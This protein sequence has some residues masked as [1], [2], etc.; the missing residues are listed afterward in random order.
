MT[1]TYDDANTWRRELIELL[2]ERDR[3][4]KENAALKLQIQQLQNAGAQLT[5]ELALSWLPALAACDGWDRLALGQ[6]R[7]DAAAGRVDGLGLRALVMDLRA[8]PAS[9]TD[10]I[11]W[12]ANERRRVE[13]GGGIPARPAPD[14]VQPIQ[15]TSWLL[16]QRQP[17]LGDSFTALTKGLRGRLP[18]V[19]ETGFLLWGDRAVAMLSTDPAQVVEALLAEVRRVS[20]ATRAESRRFFFDLFGGAAAKQQAR[21]VLGVGPEASQGEIKQAY[22]QLARQHHPDAGG[23][24]EQFHRIQQAY[25]LLAQPAVAGAG[26]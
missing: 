8:V 19:I 21:Q 14:R 3:L 12:D 4:A 23:D 10:R 7:W 5:P 20:E 17:G 26:R 11:I 16:N 18:L 22:R 15:A 1:L 6:V 9:A 24:S 13:N 2:L 25:E